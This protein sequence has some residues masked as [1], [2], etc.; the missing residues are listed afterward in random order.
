MVRQMC[1]AR[2]VAH[3]RPSVSAPRLVPADTS[4]IDG[5]RSILTCKQVVNKAKGI[6][7]KVLRFNPHQ[8]QQCITGT[9]PHGT[10]S[11]CRSCIRRN[12]RCVSTWLRSKLE[13]LTRTVRKEVCLQSTFRL[14]VERV[15]CKIDTLVCCTSTSRVTP[16]S[17]DGGMG[18]HNC[19]VPESRHGPGKLWYAFLR[20]NA[21][22]MSIPAAATYTRHEEDGHLMLKTSF[23]RPI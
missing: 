16:G 7:P 20:R 23:K 15:S 19:C 8:H 18:E 1:H 5:S 14:G 6:T 10:A 3:V 11:H 21:N 2:R 4:M 12:L 9:A 13:P 22:K 17:C